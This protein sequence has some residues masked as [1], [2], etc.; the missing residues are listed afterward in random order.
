MMTLETKI[1]KKIHSFDPVSL[2]HLLDF[3]GYRPEEILF[4]SH[5]STSSQS[6][7]IQGIEFHQEPVRQVIIS[8]NLGLLSAQSPLPSYFLKKMDKGSIDTLCFIDFI[9]YFDHFLILNYLINLYPELNTKIHADWELTKRRYLLMLDFKSCSTLHW[10]FQLA[11]PE[12]EV[13]VEKAMLQRVLQT[14]RIC[15]GETILGTDAMFGEEKAVPIYGRQITLF[16]EDELTDSGE[17]WPREIKKRLDDLVFPILSSVGIDLEIVLTIR[18]QKSWVKL[19]CE[20]YLGYDNMQGGK[21]S[22]RRI[23]IFRG[24]FREAGC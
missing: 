7:L 4:K 5:M 18:A 21:A 6:S 2:L 10:L 14:N 15:L 24:Q 22:Y 16:S 20:S 12:L 9:E 17:P 23:R 8:V 3:L 11:Y 19:S 13:R 1:A